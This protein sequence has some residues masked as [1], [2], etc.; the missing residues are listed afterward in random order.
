[1]TDAFFPLYTWLV[2]IPFALSWT[3][4]CTVIVILLTV[5]MPVFTE[6]WMPRI[7]AKPNYW[8]LYLA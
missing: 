4:M 2:Y 5:L 7:W 3:L 8:H 1:M 6:H